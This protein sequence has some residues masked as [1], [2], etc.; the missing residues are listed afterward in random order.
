MNHT[1]Q[2]K[3]LHISKEVLKATEDMGFSV[4]TPIQSQSI[5]EIL[6]GIDIIG[7]ASTGTGKTA[8]FAIPAIEKIDESN[9]DVQVLVLCP[10]RELAMQVAAEI[11]KLSKHKRRISALAVYGGE[12]IHRQLSALRRKPQIVVGTPGRTIDHMERGSL[13]ISNAKM[14]VL[15]EADEM[16]NMGFRRDIERIL[17]VTRDDRQT[18][19]FSAT[20][21]KDIL[22]LT[23]RYQK[24]P[25]IIRVAKAKQDVSSIKQSY[26][27]VEPAKKANVLVKLIDTYNP[28]LSIVFCN[29][30]RKVDKVSRIL[31]DRGFSASGIHGDIRQ[32]KRDSIMSK[33][34]K[35]RLNVLVATDV[36]ARGIDVDD[37]EIVFNYEIPKDVE[38]YV[39][40]IGRTGRAGKTG[41]ALSFVSRREFGNLRGIMRYTKTDIKKQWVPSLGE[42]K[43]IA[44]QRKEDKLQTEAEQIF[45]KVKQYVK[46]DDLKKY[47]QMMRE[48]LGQNKK[49]T[50]KSFYSSDVA[51]A[52]LKILMEE[53]NVTLYG[54][55][56][57]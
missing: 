35:G 31:R 56:H 52:L 46:N 37:V 50:K 18:V 44:T 42:V 26:F 53:N 23:K 8:A 40:R 20:M 39:H 19:L 1:L 4:T 13:R 48:F 17:E 57:E 5:P 49:H 45:G 51:A 7:Q 27:D 16:L 29:T 43:K 54:G 21:S 3:D 11:N 38:S 47:S 24:D 25:K 41:T 34:R 6:K 2:F 32:T 36:A 28:K 22:R 33:F 9:S 12:Q 55:K 14:I 10:T 30:K 15:D